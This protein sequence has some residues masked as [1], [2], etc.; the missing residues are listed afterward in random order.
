MYF[1]NS[2]PLLYFD[3]NGEIIGKVFPFLQNY[4]D[5]NV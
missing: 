2:K 1:F 3:R 4:M 5:G